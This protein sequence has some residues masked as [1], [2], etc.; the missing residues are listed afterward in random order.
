[1]VKHIVVWTLKE[2]C[3]GPH[4]ESIKNEMK[5]SLEQLNGQIDGLEYISVQTNC[6][7]SSN[8]DII[9]EA[10]LKDETALKNFTTNPLITRTTKNSV[11][12]YTETATRIDYIY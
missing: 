10:I 6:L 12:P 11:F 7:S 1:M 5:T 2:G 4:L 8:A 9:C 3:F